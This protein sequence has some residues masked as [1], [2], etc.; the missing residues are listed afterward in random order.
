M[1]SRSMVRIVGKMMDLIVS[2]LLHWLTIGYGFYT[3]LRL[4]YPTLAM[5]HLAALTSFRET[6][7]SCSTYMAMLNPMLPLGVNLTCPL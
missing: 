6:L 5:M 4:P 2:F 7:R 3:G 1:S